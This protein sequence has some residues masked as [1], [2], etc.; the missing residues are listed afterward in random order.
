MMRCVKDE[1]QKCGDVGGGGS[2]APGLL[3]SLPKGVDGWG[4]AM[5]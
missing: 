1:T 3:L 2:A 5:W 4:A